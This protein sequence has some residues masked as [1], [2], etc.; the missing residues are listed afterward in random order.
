MT[1][2]YDIDIYVLKNHSVE[3]APMLLEKRHSEDVPSKVD[4]A[5]T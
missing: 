5:A 2:A 1:Y 3:F 4:I